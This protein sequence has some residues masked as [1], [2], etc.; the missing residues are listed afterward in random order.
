MTRICSNGEHF[1]ISL[2]VISLRF[3]KSR[4]VGRNRVE[5]LAASPLDDAVVNVVADAVVAETRDTKKDS[6]KTNNQSTVGL[7][8]L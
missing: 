8:I 5:P 2:A 1:E 6:H 4:T 7:S 3:K